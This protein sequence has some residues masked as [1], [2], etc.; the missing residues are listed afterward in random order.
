MAIIQV[1]GD[2]SLDWNGSNESCEKRLDSGYNLKKEPTR[3]FA[4]RMRD[5]KEEYK[6]FGLSN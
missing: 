5:V 1:R 2:F 4:E 6:F 3:L